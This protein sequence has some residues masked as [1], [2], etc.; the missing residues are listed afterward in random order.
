MGGRTLGD[1]HRVRLAVVQP[2]RGRVLLQPSRQS[3]RAEGHVP[4]DRRN[5]SVDAGA[6]GAL[7]A[8]GRVLQL[9]GHPAR[10]QSPRGHRRDLVCGRNERS[11]SPHEL[12]PRVR[13]RTGVVHQHGTHGRDVLRATVPQA[14][15]GRHQV[16]DGGDARLQARASRRE[17]L[18]EG[19]ARDTARGAGGARGAPARRARAVHPAARQDHA[20]DSE[21]E[22]D[23]ADRRHPGESEIHNRRSGG[24]RAARPRR[25]SELRAERLRVHVL[26][27]RRH[28][29]EERAVALHHARRLDRHGERKGDARDPD[30]AR[31]VLP[32]RRLDRLRR[33]RQPLHVHRRQLESLHERLRADRRAAESLTVG[34]AEIVGEHERPAWQDHPYP[35]GARRQLHHP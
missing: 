13:R 33:E 9:Q 27:A 6:A 15:A 19:G 2:A 35:S 3:E 17:P 25:R 26:L 11:A 31:P 18:H 32:H 7:G 22:R 4:R 10:H 29:A 20:L 5:A 21:V 16:G 1:G 24:G 14:P 12:V 23:A 28:R 8:H 34:R 30:A